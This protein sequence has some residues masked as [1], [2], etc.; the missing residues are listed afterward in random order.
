MKPASKLALLA[1]LGSFPGTVVRYAPPRFSG[2][3]ALTL[4]IDSSPSSPASA[5]S[6]T[7]VLSPVAAAGTPTATGRY[8]V[9]LGGSGLGPD[10]GPAMAR[11][12]ASDSAEIVL[13]PSARGPRIDLAGRWRLGGLEGR[14]VSVGGG[15]A[16][17]GRFSLRAAR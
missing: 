6:G 10:E 17:G 8:R 2:R 16:A 1:V 3:F 11:A 7:V 14:W 5:M 12:I 4:I 13:N 9:P 15:R